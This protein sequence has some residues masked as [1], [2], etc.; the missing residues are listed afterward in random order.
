MIN[1]CPGVQILFCLSIILSFLYMDVSGISTTAVDSFG[2]HL[3]RNIGRKSSTE[4]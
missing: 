1:P 3:I 4:I 2:Q